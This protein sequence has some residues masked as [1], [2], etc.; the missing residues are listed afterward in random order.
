MG[1]S[2]MMRD[3]HERENSAANENVKLDS[4]PGMSLLNTPLPQTFVLMT[5]EH[6]RS[7]N[8]KMALICLVLLTA[9]GA[10]GWALTIVTSQPPV[11][12]TYMT[13]SDGKLIDY[14]P[15]NL[16]TLTDAQ[17]LEWAA[18]TM[19]KTQAYSFSN[20]DSQLKANYVY[21]NGSG[22]KSYQ[23]ALADSQLKPKL[24]KERLT[25]WLEPLEAPRILKRGP[26]QGALGY[27][28]LYKY[29][30]FFE[31]G[32][33]SRRTPPLQATLL[34]KRAPRNESNPA[35]LQ[36]VSYLVKQGGGD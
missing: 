36:I 15:T 10:L 20:F 33:I 1:D 2:T 34:V 3:R 14:T 18:D 29:V 4:V 19:D 12:L 5:G 6:Y 35:G 30:Q 27:E 24:M 28:I 32:A 13:D 11:T 22:W 31:G 9:V 17:V 25:T 23:R 8:Q 26:I 16:P 21:F 7:M